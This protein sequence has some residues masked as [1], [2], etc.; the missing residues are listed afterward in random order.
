MFV[1]G[2]G[3]GDQPGLLCSA[4]RFPLPGTEGGSPQTQERGGCEATSPPWKLSLHLPTGLKFTHGLGT[5]TP[6]S[7]P[8]NADL[9]LPRF[10]EHLLCAGRPDVCL[11]ASDRVYVQLLLP[12]DTPAACRCRG[13]GWE[14]QLPEGARGLCS[15]NEWV[16]E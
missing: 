16:S 11:L 3:G 1:S 14:G 7:T 15:L 5:L 10:T 8:E 4:P 13:W 6:K 12:A 2:G 9:I